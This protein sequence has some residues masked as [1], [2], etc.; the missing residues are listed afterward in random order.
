MVRKCNPN[1][2]FKK[3]PQCGGLITGRSH[4]RAK[5]CSRKC[6][7]A[8]QVGRPSNKPLAAMKRAKLSIAALPPR[9]C[10]Q[11]GKKIVR[12]THQQKDGT[13]RKDTAY[14]LSKRKYC[15]HK[16]LW[17]AKILPIPSRHVCYKDASSVVAVKCSRCGE[18]DRR[19][20]RHHDDY[21]KPLRVT[22]LCDKCHRRE[23]GARGA[24]ALAKLRKGCLLCGHP[25]KGSGLC[26]VHLLQKKKTGNA[27]WKFARIKGRGV[28]LIDELTKEIVK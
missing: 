24:Y 2:F 4:L 10:R 13:F 19:I 6:F 3:C 22:I 7:N 14:H 26:S 15:S 9:F 5:Y 28:V 18:T 23:H 20:H 27:R 25:E 17:A 16:C 8:T 1:R 21:T 11:C 12:K